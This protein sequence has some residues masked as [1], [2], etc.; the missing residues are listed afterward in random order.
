MEFTA[1]EI[2]AAVQR[3]MLTARAATQRA[4]HRIEQTQPIFNAWQ[5]IR[6]DAALAEADAI[7]ARDDRGSLPLAGVPIAIKDNIAVAGEP[8]RDG[9][10]ATSAAPRA[11]DHE[12]VRRLRAAG[13]V[14]VGLTRVPELCIWGATDSAF[15]VTRNPWNPERTPGG[16]SGG[17][18]AAVASG[19][20]PIA[21]GNDGMGS[22]RIPAACCGLVG[23]KPGHGVVPVGE[24]HASWGGMS[25]NGPLATTVAD[26]A[27]MFSVMA[28]DPDAAVL[29]PGP[30]LRIAVS[31]SAPSLATPVAR[32]W[33]ETV[34]RTADLLRGG[35]HVI[36]SATPRYP[37]TLMNTTALAL[38]TAG[39]A[40]DARASV[41]TSLLERRNRIHVRIGDA[42]EKRGL[43]NPKGREVW[44][45]RAFDFFAD[46]DVLV[47]PTLA[48]PPIRSRRWA[49]RGWLTSLV[50]NARYA[51][52]AAP[53]NIIGWP[54]M[55]VPAGLDR[56][57]LPVGVQLVG[58]PG[59]ERTLLGLAAHLERLQPWPRTA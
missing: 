45:Q 53:W 5:V 1:T 52:F 51:P 39:A 42:V 24:A 54:A 47:T 12:V 25:E 44:R 16:S 3:G 33:A 30:T 28:D 18:A 14:I 23:L 46:T 29:I 48:Q 4:L 26:A 50:T 6:N 34:H 59:S 10:L 27:L 43:A 13:A 56:H 58:K 31:T 17:S 35:G 32:D 22:I 38:W 37:A 20:V 8:M 40:A 57:G 36:R 41:N 2:A 49:Q 21:H 15:G 9:T 11:A 55:N 19:A 7:D